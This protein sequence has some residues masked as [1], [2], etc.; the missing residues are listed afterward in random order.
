MLIDADAEACSRAVSF[1]SSSA[2][3]AVK[4]PAKASPA[5][6]GSTTFLTG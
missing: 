3:E 5:P 1:D 6:V 4:A 2:N